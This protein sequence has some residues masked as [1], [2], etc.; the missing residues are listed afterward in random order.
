MARIL[1]NLVRADVN[2]VRHL[3]LP[4]P[5]T[6]TTNMFYGDVSHNIFTEVTK[7]LNFRPAAIHQGC[8]KIFVLLDK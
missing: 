4:T 1:V 5:V 8:I 6:A 3:L 2:A 7:D